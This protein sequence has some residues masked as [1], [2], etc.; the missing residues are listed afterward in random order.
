MFS[1]KSVGAM[2][3]NRMWAG[4]CGVVLDGEPVLECSLELCSVCPMLALFLGGARRVFVTDLSMLVLSLADGTSSC[5]DDDD[6]LP[7]PAGGAALLSVLFP[8]VLLLPFWS[9]A[10]CVLLVRDVSSLPCAGV[11]LE[12]PGGGFES[13]LRTLRRRFFGLSA[14]F[15]CCVWESA[16]EG[17]IDAACAPC[18]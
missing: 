11:V 12:G 2:L 13:C 3:L 1:V 15:G 16:E 4:R 14:L 17:F 18:L 7:M 9:D 8:D 10:G 5:P 6:F